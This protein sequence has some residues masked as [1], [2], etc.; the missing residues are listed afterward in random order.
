MSAPNLASKTARERLQPRREPYFVRIDAG[1]Y[2]GFRRI[3]ATADGTWVARK[4]S[5]DGGKQI[6]NSLGSTA[7]LEFDAAVKLANK[8]AA[9]GA[10]TKEITKA[11]V[12]EAA[13]RYVEN[14]RLHKGADAARDATTRFNRLVYGNPIAKIELA[15]LKASDINAW[16]AFQI[17]SEAEPD[18]I[19][20]AKNSANRSLANFKAALNLAFKEGLV[21]SNSAWVHVSKFAKVSGTRDGFLTK[22]QRADLI[23]ECEPDLAAFVRGLLLTA[24]RPG[25]LAK[26]NVSD[27]NKHRGTLALSGKTGP[28]V[29]SLSKAAIA[30]FSEVSQ[31]RIGAAPLF[32]TFDGK[33]FWVGRWS[34]E[35]RKA[36]KASG[37]PLDACA[38]Y[39]RHTAIS[40][41]LMAGI[42]PFVVAK[43]SG[44]ST[45]IIDQTYGHITADRARELLDSVSMF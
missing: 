16:I 35:F 11:T 8:W 14:R 5:E 43:Q 23:G 13:E 42:S 17:P 22:E 25:E 34:R 21:A 3:S 33:R 6:Y 30:L 36:V 40:E 10:P 20:A 24:S 2:I 19:R 45:K 38:Y 18:K 12:K 44:T 32:E 31:D 26:A 39:L 27:F 41:M 1:I 28:R 9:H 4:R 7:D 15:K 37:L 29:I